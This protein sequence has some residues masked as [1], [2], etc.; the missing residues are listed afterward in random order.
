MIF[1]EGS[2]I[3]ENYKRYRQSDKLCYIGVFMKPD[4]FTGAIEN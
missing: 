1:E 4:F 3:Y 2:R